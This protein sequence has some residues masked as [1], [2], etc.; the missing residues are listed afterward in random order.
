[1]KWVSSQYAIIISLDYW[2]YDYFLRRV[3][4]AA[5]HFSITH[6]GDVV[7]APLHITEKKTPFQFP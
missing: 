2:I 7:A 6:E 3:G 5:Y 1:M 4:N